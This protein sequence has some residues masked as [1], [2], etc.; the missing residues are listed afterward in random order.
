MKCIVHIKKNYAFSGLINNFNLIN[1]TYRVFKIFAPPSRAKSRKAPA[2]PTISPSNT[3]NLKRG[4][5]KPAPET[6]Q[7]RCK[8]NFPKKRSRMETAGTPRTPSHLPSC[9]QSLRAKQT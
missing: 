5:Q 2:K 7:N 4:H 1:A 3:F 8:T 6:L 9:P